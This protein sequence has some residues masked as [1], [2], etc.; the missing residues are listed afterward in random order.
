VATWSPLFFI[1][2]LISLPQL[3]NVKRSILTITLFHLILAGAFAQGRLSLATDVGLLRNLGEKQKF[4]SAGQTIQGNYHIS[5][6]HT[7]Y[8]WFKYY[9]PGKFSNEF[10]ATARDLATSPQQVNYRVNSS[11]AYREF[12]LGWKHFIKGSYDA[13]E[14]WNLYTITGL[15]IMFARSESTT[16]LDTAL[17]QPAQ[18]P[19]LGNKNFTR[20]NLDLGIGGEMPLGANIYIYSDLRTWINTSS[21]PSDVFHSEK[22][23]TFPLM[24]HAGIRLLFD[25]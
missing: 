5:P 22:N 4:W 10:T 12:S 6:T 21:Y 16:S 9:I 8:V 7:A 20:L 13:A 24:L 23:A 18:R 1:Q 2:L 14:G 11:W 19:F 3:E 17:Y 15:G 25:Y